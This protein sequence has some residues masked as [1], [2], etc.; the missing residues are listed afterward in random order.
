MN[1]L[2]PFLVITF[3]I[4]LAFLIGKL[5]SQKK[6]GFLKSFFISII[7]SPFISYMVVSNSRMKNPRGCNQCGNMENE[8]VFCGMCGKNEVGLTRKQVSQK[9]N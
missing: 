5:G 3:W 1:S 4:G 6:I 8:A 9:L 2:I 7:F